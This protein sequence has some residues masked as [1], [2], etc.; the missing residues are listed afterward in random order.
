MVKSVCVDKSQQPGHPLADKYVNCE[1]SEILWIYSGCM[2]CEKLFYGSMFQNQCH[3][4]TCLLFFL[5]C[6]DRNLI[7]ISMSTSSPLPSKATT[8]NINWQPTHNPGNIIFMKKKSLLFMFLLH[9]LSFFLLLY[10][11]RPK[12]L[13]IHMHIKRI[14]M[15]Y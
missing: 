8:D 7:E 3:S 13:L 9:C 15:K 11:F 2:Y 1:L 12:G 6:H 4:S 5:I 14:N 10:P